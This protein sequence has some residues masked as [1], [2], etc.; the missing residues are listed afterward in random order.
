MRRAPGEGKGHG[1][2]VGGGGWGESFCV[3]LFS[4]INEYQ[5]DDKPSQNTELRNGANV[6]FSMIFFPD[7]CI[8]SAY[9]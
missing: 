6:G 2:N 1:S 4:I 5:H 7:I 9:C 8:K 3:I